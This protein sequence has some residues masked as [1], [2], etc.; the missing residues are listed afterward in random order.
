MNFLVALSGLGETTSTGNI[1]FKQASV[2]LARF[3]V[4]PILSLASILIAQWPLCYLN[5]LDQQLISVA[6]SQVQGDVALMLHLLRL[7]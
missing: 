4:D 1:M 3:R 7:A 2:R 6:A 5:Y